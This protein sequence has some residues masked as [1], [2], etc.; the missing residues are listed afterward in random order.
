MNTNKRKY[1]TLF[2]GEADNMT[3][4]HCQIHIETEHEG[5]VEDSDN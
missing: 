3:L 2:G 4:V 5:A 1:K